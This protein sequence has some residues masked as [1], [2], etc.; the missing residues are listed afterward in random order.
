M[1]TE[2]IVT[3]VVLGGAYWAYRCHH[4]EEC[5]FNGECKTVYKHILQGRS[6]TADQAQKY[7]GIKHLRSVISRLRHKYNLDIETVTKDRKATYKKK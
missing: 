2:L 5:K 4:S 7:Y 1:I 3:G 6:I